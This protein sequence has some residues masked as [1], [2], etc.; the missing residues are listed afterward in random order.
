MFG[1]RAAK[2]WMALILAAFVLPGLVLAA[3]VSTRDPGGVYPPPV[4]RDL[5]AIVARDTLVALTSTN[6]T[7]YFLYRGQALGYEYE[8]LQ[9]FAEDAGVVLEMRVV[10]RDSLLY[11]LNLGYGD[12]AAARIVPSEQDTANFAYTTELYRTRPTLVQREDPSPG[13]ALLAPV[14][15]LL[16]MGDTVEV[17]VRRISRPEELGGE[18]V[19][20]PQDSP[21]IERLLELEDE[22]TGDIRVV[23]VDTTSEALIRQVATAEVPLTV[24]QENVA[25][26]EESYYTNLAVTP[27][28]GAEHPVS[29]AVRANA[30]GL[31][32]ALNA[33][34]EEHRDSGRWRALYQK[35]YV[36]RRGYRERVASRYL[37]GVT[38]ALSEWDA[39][40]KRHAAEAG[41]DWRLLAAQT[42]QESRFDAR[43]TSWA[44]AMGL[45]QIMPATARDLGVADPYDPDANVAG[46]VRYLRWLQ[47]EYWDDAIADPQ[48]RLKFTL[49]SYNAGAGHVMDAQR[50]ARKH[51][52]DP[53][54]WADVAFWLLRLSEAEW[55]NDPVVRHGYCRGLEPVEY[56][57]RILDRFAHYRQFVSAAP[58]A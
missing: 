40:L 26:L 7:S 3:Y 58:E 48:E 34:I 4:D 14:D 11:L 56:V 9:D 45:L 2:R 36:D 30:P 12:V 37:T 27:A 31:L 35:Y 16:G 19:Y 46:A 13:D 20:V 22:V 32:R 18:A 10:P 29:W 1:T 55:Y 24:A 41:W 6:S 28:I 50:L 52:D 15:S 54:R 42:Y 17:A 21:Y 8:L 51:G 33:W 38:G 53:A 43:A 47:A 44:G 5:A 23:V 49:A 25:D 39:V 57:A